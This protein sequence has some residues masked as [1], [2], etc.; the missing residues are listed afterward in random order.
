MVSK[1]AKEKKMMRHHGGNW[2]SWTRTA[3]D[4]EIRDFSSN[5]NPYGPPAK[6]FKVLKDNLAKITTYPDNLARSLREKIAEYIKV[7]VANILV[8]NGSA[9]LIFLLAC[10]FRPRS[11]LIPVPSFCEYELAMDSAGAR[12]I[13][14]YLRQELNFVIQDYE[15][16]HD[17]DLVI[18]GNP[19]N[20]TGQITPKDK[21][22]AFL[23]D[24]NSRPVLLVDE[25]FMDF[26]PDAQHYSL[27]EEAVKRQN[28]IVL[29]SLT[30]FFSLAGLRLGYLV[31]ERK[32]ISK[33]AKWRYP[34]GVNTLAQIAGVAAL[35]DKEYIEQSILL[36]KLA[37]EQ[38]IEELDRLNWL[39]VY[40]SAAN[41]LLLEIKNQAI[42]SQS[43]CERMAKKGFII[44]DC[45]PFRGLR[46]FFIRV[47]V[48]QPEVNRQLVCELA[49]LEN[50]LM[51]G[52][53]V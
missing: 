17:F 1:L 11:V 14:M 45:A 30:K 39:K 4:E 44:R 34:W 18:I 2:S 38:L 10:Y 27:A 49:K 29:R 13:F 26:V 19:N 43:L 35:S 37:R 32:L 42:T 16:K 33:L 21:L 12:L 7:P 51:A 23:D 46:P 36:T 40:P 20:P 6:V 24:K 9:E 3:V 41:F 28:L 31:A 47:A 53:K 5:V 8:G 52:G 50:Q 22:L 48:K 25:A 15:S